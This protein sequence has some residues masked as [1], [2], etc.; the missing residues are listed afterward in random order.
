MSGIL[1]LIGLIGS[2]LLSVW[3][4]FKYLLTSSYRLEDG[5]SKLLLSRIRKEKPPSWVFGGEHVTPPRFPELWE[6]FLLLD[7]IPLYF[8]RNERL[9][10]AGW[11]SKESVSTL[12]F[13]RWNRSG[14]DRL[15]AQVN[16]GESIQVSALTP[17]GTD[18]LGELEPGGEGELYLNPGSYE[19]IEEDVRRVVAGELNKTGALLYGPP[20]NGKTRFVRYLSKKYSLPIN[21]VYFLPDYNNLDISLMFA[22]VPQR[23]IVLLEDFDNLFDGRK[24]TMPNDQVKFTFD[25]II[26]SLDGVHNDYRQVV[27]IMTV[28]D[29]GKVDDS[30]KERPSRFKFVKEFIPPCLEVRERILGD[31]NLA[32]ITDGLSLDKVVHFKI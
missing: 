6:G 31:K 29:I 26:N 23:S 7:K 32:I 15:L 16:T 17:H 20:G 11:K 19:D 5:V 1:P 4:A 13:F 2:T 27:F 21:V 18:R 28:N 30:I 3:A 8:H 12:S 10:T 14:V 25:S 9:M 24:C 22:N